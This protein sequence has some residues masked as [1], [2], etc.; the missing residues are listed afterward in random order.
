MFFPKAILTNYIN[1]NSL[2]TF[3]KKITRAIAQNGESSCT[4]IYTWKLG[5]RHSWYILVSEGEAKSRINNN[6]GI[7]I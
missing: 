3:Q 1:L 4:L 2:V 6:Q 7:Y 5:L